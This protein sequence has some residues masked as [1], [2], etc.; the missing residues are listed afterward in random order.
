MREYENYCVDCDLP[1]IGDSCSNKN[2]PIDYCDICKKEYADYKI[3][4][5]YFCKSC[6]KKYIKGIFYDLPLSEQAELLNIDLEL[7]E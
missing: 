5:I 3:E 2:V 4:Q 6:V 1:C 7:I